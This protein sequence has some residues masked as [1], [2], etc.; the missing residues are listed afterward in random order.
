MCCASRRRRAASWSARAPRS[1]RARSA[2]H[3]VNWIG[4]GAIDDAERR[5]VFVKVRSTREPRP[6]WL[7]LGRDGVEV[8]LIDGEEGVAPG[9]ACV[10][11][12]SAEGGA[13]MLGGGFIRSAEAVHADRCGDAL[14]PAFESFAERGDGGHSRSERGRTRLCALGAGLRSGVRQGVRA[15]APRFDRGGRAGRRAH[16][17]GRRRHRHLAARLRAHQS[18]GRHRHLG[19]DAAQGAGARRRARPHQCRG[20][21]RDGREA[22]RLSG[23]RLRR[24]RGAI[25]HHGGAGP[26]SD[27]R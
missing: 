6:A 3:D 25:R 1:R 26:G 14:R 24:D 20:A 21:R 17:R 7:S 4:D 13:R 19:A 18:P 8:E 5:E 11:Y 16:P 23:R 9:Q 15:R 12:D 10:F 2:L 27:A 22:S